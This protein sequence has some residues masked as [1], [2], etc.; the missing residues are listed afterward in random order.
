M[1]LK[2]LRLPAEAEARAQ[3]ALFESPG[4]PRRG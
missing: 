1:Q 2:V 4:V 3:S